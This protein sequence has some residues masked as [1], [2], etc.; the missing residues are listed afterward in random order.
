MF[1]FT[2]A[3]V[4]PALQNASQ[5][6]PTWVEPTPRSGE[7]VGRVVSSSL[8]KQLSSASDTDRSQGP[9]AKP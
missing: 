1:I 2:D 8:F 7:T 9:K 4:I 3:E 5:A 6:P